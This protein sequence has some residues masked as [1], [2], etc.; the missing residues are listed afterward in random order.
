MDANIMNKSVLVKLTLSFC[1][2]LA[3]PASGHAQ[4][5]RDYMIIVGS[6]TIAPFSEMVVEHFVKTNGMETPMVQPSGSGGGLMLFCMGNDPLD[7]DMAYA[8]RPIRES[9]YETCQKNGVTD[10]V[11]IKIGYDGIVMAHAKDAPVID[12]TRRD[13][14]L[15][16]AETVPGPEGGESY[17]K[18]PYKTWKDVRA[19][20]PD[21]PIKV[22]GPSKG[23]GTRYVFSRL[24]MEEGCRT[25]EQIIALEDED[26]W[27]YKSTCRS[28][29]DDGAYVE[30]GEDDEVTVEKLD[31]NPTAI[32]ITS[33]GVVD[34]N[35]ITIRS[36]P[37]DGI[38]PDFENIANGSYL[39][40]RPLFIYVKKANV[41]TNPGI[42]EF[43]SEFTSEAA[44]GPA[45]YLRQRGLVAMS[46]DKRTSYRDVA[47]KLTPMVM[48]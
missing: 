27:L 15:A 17:I 14:Y 25:F 41:G 43:L 4:N 46:E 30:I 29:R 18:N 2:L 48:K 32:A 31:A 28:F 9:E 37:I 6:T 10:I 26:L 42:A 24:A 12:L 45:G 19:S 47:I 23:S 13:I 34:Q 7:P 40:A 39:I 33:F 3:I 20:L 22:W 16:L 1:F 35:E 5:Q 38:K 36:I 21:M 8:S 44:W 11:E